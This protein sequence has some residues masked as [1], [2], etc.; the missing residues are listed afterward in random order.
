MVQLNDKW[1]FI[2][3]DGTF[4]SEQWFDDCKNFSEGF[5]VVELNNKY[6]VIDKNGKLYNYFGYKIQKFFKYIVR[7]FNK[8]FGKR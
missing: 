5:A 4:L 2:R 7:N 3:P 8:L 6:Y 1:N